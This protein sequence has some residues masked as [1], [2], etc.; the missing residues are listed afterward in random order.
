M[1]DVQMCMKAVA[2]ISS[3]SGGGSVPVLVSLFERRWM[4][5]YAC[6]MGDY[7]LSNAH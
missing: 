7:V 1:S 3:Q 2:I 5:L 4:S 6:R